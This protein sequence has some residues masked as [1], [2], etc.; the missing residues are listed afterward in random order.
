MITV[1]SWGGHGTQ[2]EQGHALQ[3]RVKERSGGH[4]GPQRWMTLLAQFIP[5]PALKLV[6]L[7]SVNTRPDEATL[8][9]YPGGGS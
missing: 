5:S 3:L 6:L 9:Q 4:G 7:L 8:I 1:K 2:P